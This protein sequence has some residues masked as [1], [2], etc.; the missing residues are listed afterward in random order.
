MVWV[1]NQPRNSP[2]PKVSECLFSVF[3]FTGSNSSLSSGKSLHA[4][5]S[6]PW[7]SGSFLG[8]QRT[9]FWT[10]SSSCQNPSE[11]TDIWEIEFR[12]M[13]SPVCAK[14]YPWS[15]ESS[16]CGAHYVSLSWPKLFHGLCFNVKSLS[17]FFLK[18]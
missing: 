1:D 11:T 13:Y 9:Q 5:N 14:L 10:G 3:L 15:P 12:G 18:H 6:Y 16:K 4:T 17:F 2:S 8:P 7:M